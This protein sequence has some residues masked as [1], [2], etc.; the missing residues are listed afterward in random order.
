MYDKVS[1]DAAANYTI[2]AGHDQTYK[3]AVPGQDVSAISVGY[4]YKF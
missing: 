4:V 1:N 3:N 2:G